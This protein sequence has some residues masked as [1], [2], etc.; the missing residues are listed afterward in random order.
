MDFGLDMLRQS[1]VT[2]TMAVSPLSVI[3]ALA[4]VQVG[5]KGETKEQ[6]N[7]KISD[8]ATDDQIVDFYSNLANSTL[9]A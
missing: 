6:I 9:N 4:L 8:G 7:E 5:A 1:P 2:E 3:F